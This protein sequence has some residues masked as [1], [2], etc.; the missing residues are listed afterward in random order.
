VPYLNCPN[1]QMSLFS[2]AKYSMAREC[3]RCL[4]LF[5]RRVPMFV[6]AHRYEAPFGFRPG[7]SSKSQRQ[8]ASR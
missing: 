5:D 1:C 3:P 8:P 4:G 7:A 2:A 6:T